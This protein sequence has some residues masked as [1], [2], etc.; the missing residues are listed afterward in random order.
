MPSCR[1]ADNLLFPPACLSIC[2]LAFATSLQF[3]TAARLLYALQLLVQL[4]QSRYSCSLAEDEE[5][6]AQQ[7][8]QPRLSAAVLARVGEKRVLQELSQVR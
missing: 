2:L 8:Q 4:M 3:C 6:L 1:C 5:R 7:Q